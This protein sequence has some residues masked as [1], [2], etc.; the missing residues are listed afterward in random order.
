MS[1]M[2]WLRC[3]D[4]LQDKMSAQLFDTW[5]KP[6]RGEL[7]GEELRLFAPNS[8]IRERVRDMYFDEIGLALR[9]LYPQ[10][11]FT[12]DLRIDSHYGGGAAA[13]NGATSGN[14]AAAGN[15][16]TA[17]NGAAMMPG[18]PALLDELAGNLVDGVDDLAAANKAA[19]ESVES[20]LFQHP[21]PAAGAQ[22]GPLETPPWGQ[23]HFNENFTFENFVVGKSNQQAC[24][25]AKNVAESPGKHYSNP[26]L[27]YGGTGLGKTHLMHAVGNAI[28]KRDP[29]QQVLYMHAEGFVSQMVEAIQHGTMNA[30]K[31]H[32]R[33]VDVLLIDDIQ[34]FFGKERSLEEF[35]HTFNALLDRGR[36]T[37]FSCDRYPKESESFDARLKSR[38]SMGM[39][40]P[41]E[42]PELET[43]A[44]ILKRKAQEQ[45]VD[46]PDDVALFI[47]ER[48]QSNV[49]ELEGALNRV[50][51][52]AAHNDRPID[53]PQTK[54]ALADILAAHAKQVRLDY[55]QKEA[56]SY[57]KIKVSDMVSKSRRRS[58]ARP[59]QMAMALAR[60][61]TNHSLPEIGDAFGGRDHTTVMHAC[62]KIE[63]LRKMDPNTEE[64]HRNLL[65]ILKP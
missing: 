62:S 11:S 37:I 3:V 15:G 19:K 46:L 24:A 56:A 55:I 53:I 32:Y 57:Y 40:V 36:Q 22:A 26:L 21:A 12:V 52:D 42:H 49:R 17:G 9:E 8:L 29:N 44:A 39:S 23:S 31:Q 10:S 65:R 45:K 54:E 28:L 33:S 43:R 30:F 34:F 16:A 5:I 27:L 18:S 35:F 50:I 6:L 25:E 13:G 38:L 58:V 2:V 14:G 51:G 61:L 59:R 64:D 60:E 20:G 63:E 47:A 7:E 1:D 41:L 4:K 48:I